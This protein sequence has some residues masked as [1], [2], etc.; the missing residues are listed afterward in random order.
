MS[1][2]VDLPVL[3]SLCRIFLL[4]ES[5]LELEDLVLPFLQANPQV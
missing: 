4:V 5:C 2:S 3:V 1:I